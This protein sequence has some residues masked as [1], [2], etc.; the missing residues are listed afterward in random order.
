M[1]ELIQT[2]M[3]T[4]IVNCFVVSWGS[5]CPSKHAAYDTA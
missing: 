4:A 3:N 2:C 1:V 5:A